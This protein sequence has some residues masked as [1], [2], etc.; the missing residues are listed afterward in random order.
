MKLR[1]ALLLTTLMSVA[2]FLNYAN[3][4]LT[5]QDWSTFTLA[6]VLIL[7]TVCRTA[8]Y[9][10][11][12]QNVNTAGKMYTLCKEMHKVACERNV[13]YENQVSLNLFFIVHNQNISM[14]RFTNI[15]K[16][17]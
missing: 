2:H 8:I 6:T 10:N 15:Y 13:T 5:Q 11:K 16:K 17:F 14:M 4:Y 1:T 9:I 12:C 7:V 3:Y